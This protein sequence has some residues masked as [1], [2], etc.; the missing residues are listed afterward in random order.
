MYSLL[1]EQVASTVIC[2]TNMRQRSKEIFII[3]YYGDTNIMEHF[4]S[5]HPIASAFN[6]YCH[7]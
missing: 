4:D 5:R 1:I 3:P 2:R 7:E 6:F